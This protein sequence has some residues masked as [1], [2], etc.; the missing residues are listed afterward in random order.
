MESGRGR[1]GKGRG[2]IKN[3]GADMVRERWEKKG[4]D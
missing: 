2:R 4:G 1:M 3:V